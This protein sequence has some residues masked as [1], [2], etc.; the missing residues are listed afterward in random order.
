MTAL[1]YFPACEDENVGITEHEDGNCITFV[2]QDGV[3][4]LQV[5][6][7]GHWIPVVPADGT[8]V[9]NVGDVIQVIHLLYIYVCYSILISF[10]LSLI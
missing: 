2:L 6:K 8:I 5:R 10:D 1:R 3:G 9:V 4:G 7:N